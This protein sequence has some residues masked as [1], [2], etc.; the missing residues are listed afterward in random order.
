MWVTY[1]LVVK[2]CMHVRIIVQASV[3]M[4]CVSLLTQG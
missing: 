1:G 3:C 2:N 4:F